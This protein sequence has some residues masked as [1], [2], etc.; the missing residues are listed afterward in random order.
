M[1]RNVQIQ[2]DD[3]DIEYSDD[4][5]HER[6]EATREFQHMSLYGDMKHGAAVSVDFTKRNSLVLVSFILHELMNIIWHCHI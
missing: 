1:E 2:A 6:E 3:I 4:T 5:R